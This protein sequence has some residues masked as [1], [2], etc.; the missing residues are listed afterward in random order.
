M[1]AWTTLV[2][3]LQ[4]KRQKQTYLARVARLEVDKRRTERTNERVLDAIRDLNCACNA[5]EIANHTG[6]SVTFT[7]KVLARLENAGKLA[8]HKIKSGTNWVQY[9]EI[10]DGC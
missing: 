9:W 3:S 4:G 8:T 7:R 6:L 5:M 1:N 10:S 2:D